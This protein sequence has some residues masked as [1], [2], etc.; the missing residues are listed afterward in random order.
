MKMNLLD[1][2][3]GWVRTNISEAIALKLVGAKRMS[4]TISII[5]LGL[6]CLVKF[7]VLP[8]S[9]SAFIETMSES[10]DLDI[11][12]G[13]LTTEMTDLKVNFDDVVWNVRGSRGSSELFK[14]DSVSFDLSLMKYFSTGFDLTSSIHEVTVLDS[15]I[16]IEHKL[17]NRWNWQDAFNGKKLLRYVNK[18][19]KQQKE[20][21]KQQQDDDGSHF[22]LAAIHFDRLQIAWV[23][24]VPSNSGGGLI[25]RAVSEL[26]I[27][28]VSLIV[29][30]IVGIIQN[31]PQ[32][33]E[34]DLD[35]RTAD[36]VIQAS[37]E[38]N[39]FSW[40]NSV[41]RN[42]I[43]RK[44][45]MPTLELDFYLENVGA[46]AL[47]R[48]VP[49][50]AINATDGTMTGEIQIVLNMD[51]VV[52]FSTRMKLNDMSWEVNE[53]STANTGKDLAA[54]KQGLESYRHK[55]VNIVASSKGRMSD[56]NFRVLPSL[57][58]AITRE[59]VS[60]APKSVY[61]VA[62]NDQLRYED[63]E[64]SPLAR[65]LQETTQT[66]EQVEDITTQL[67][68]IG[69]AASKLERFLPFKKSPF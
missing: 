65:N 50:A 5:A 61:N 6:V 20:D 25:N 9:A 24:E 19:K 63:R 26:Y 15:K 59:A 8:G 12:I 58:T 18:L 11:K 2:I 32:P 45:W 13:G 47:G 56:P 7:Y 34:I 23:E 27:D 36:G 28:D 41:E 46:V 44:G 68:A 51:Q 14:A 29:K 40:E 38:I 54:A 42:T 55:S 22:S 69:R 1:D 48:M 60:N 35:G 39:L 3:L 52:D 66:L 62:T 57:Q 33:M 17:S 64:L 21:E 67:G 37:G 31:T 16:Y 30:N 10:Y 49:D 4:F 43:K 53:A